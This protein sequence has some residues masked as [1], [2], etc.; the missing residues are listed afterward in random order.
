MDS[1]KKRWALVFLIAVVS[2]AFY[3]LRAAPQQNELAPTNRQVESSNSAPQFRQSPVN[4]ESP[5]LAPPRT[6][7]IVKVTT[8]EAGQPMP[9]GDARVLGTVVN[10]SGQPQL[11][12]IFLRLAGDQET[13]RQTKS[14]DDGSF[15]LSGLAGGEYTVHLGPS[16]GLQRSV[17]DADPIT[18]RDGETRQGL[19]LVYD[20]GS[21]L[22]ISGHVFDPKGA[23][24]HLA[25]VMAVGQGT[26]PDA[27][28]SQEDGRFELLGLSDA[29]YQLMI[30]HPDFARAKVDGISIGTTD[31]TI[32]LEPAGSRE[33]TI[34]GRV[35][36]AITRKPIGQF[37]IAIEAEGSLYKP[38]SVA[39]TK[40]K[41]FEN[42][43]GQFSITSYPQPRTPKVLLVKARRYVPMHHYV[44]TLSNTDS[45][46]GIEVALQPAVCTVEGTVLDAAGNPIAN[47]NIAIGIPSGA[48]DM[49]ILVLSAVTDQGGDFILND[50]P[51]KLTSL[52]VTAK[53]FSPASLKTRPRPDKVVRV[54]ITLESFGTVYGIV[55]YDGQPVEAAQVIPGGVAQLVAWTD[56][57]GR[58]EIRGVAVGEVELRAIFRREQDISS[59]LESTRIAIVASGLATQADLALDLV[60]VEQEEEWEAE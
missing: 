6:P 29:D 41:Q 48:P 4:T 44:G 10:G 2:V 35:I 57:D 42:V 7:R 33:A 31:V 34:S 56:Q 40:L 53:N 38:E 15:E 43:K 9:A 17:V 59:R 46:S 21:L 13:R 50:L 14:N 47:A 60:A 45:V 32:H 20:E 19:R 28:V 58:Y 22:R 3:F 27:C 18:L 23:P 55:T 25:N 24:V 49:E 52:I 12:T 26:T 5:E 39:R 54:D 37:E 1:K 30:I 11:A 16:T 51:A 36:D 8:D